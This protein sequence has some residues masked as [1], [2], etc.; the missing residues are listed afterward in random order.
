MNR[1]KEIEE[2]SHSPKEESI[3]FSFSPL[4]NSKVKELKKIYWE[5]VISKDYFLQKKNNFHLRFFMKMCSYT[6]KLPELRTFITAYPIVREEILK[7]NL[8][9]KFTKSPIFDAY[10]QQTDLQAKG[11]VQDMIDKFSWCLS[12]EDINYPPV[13]A[14]KVAVLEE[15]IQNK[16][17]HSRPKL[18]SQNNTITAATIHLNYD[19]IVQIYQETIFPALKVSRNKKEFNNILYQ[20]YL[21]MLYTR[22][23]AKHLDDVLHEMYLRYFA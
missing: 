17:L 16:L 2:H 13:S 1:H 12:K 23:D 8:L 9:H 18:L 19:K 21:H 14:E 10:L 11:L 3:I 7:I 20:A 22:K 4:E 5:T 6:E 15:Q